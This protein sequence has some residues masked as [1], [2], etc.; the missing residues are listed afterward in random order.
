MDK[1][2]KSLNYKFIRSCR[3]KVYISENFE[4]SQLDILHEYDYFFI[5]RIGFNTQYIITPDKEYNFVTL[6]Y[7]YRVADY[8][9][10]IID[11]SFWIHDEWFNKNLA[12]YDSNM[13]HAD[14]YISKRFLRN[15]LVE[16]IM[17]NNAMYLK[18]DYSDFQKMHMFHLESAP[19]F[20]QLKEYLIYILTKNLDF[21]ESIKVYKLFE[22]IKEVNSNGK[23]EE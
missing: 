21:E 12:D 5:V 23:L 2:I 20:E 9:H 17:D 7:S 14:I 1:I 4:L 10:K 19:S 3:K 6:Q 22:N 15:N 16:V 11:Q 18:F 13:C 8:I